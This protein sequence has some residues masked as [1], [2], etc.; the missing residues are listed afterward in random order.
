LRFTVVDL[1]DLSLINMS[2]L[3]KALFGFI[4]LLIV[5][6]PGLAFAGTT[7]PYTPTYS[8]P[9]YSYASTYQYPTYSYSNPSRYYKGEHVAYTNSGY[10]SLG[11]TYVPYLPNTGFEPQSS[12]A[13][14]FALVVL[15]TLAIFSY[16]YV[17]KAFIVV[18]G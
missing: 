15:I 1:V 4:A 8:Y 5:S 13:I 12:F 6:I 7:Y 16:P 10:V 2:T 14:A 18:R 9:N 3:Y 17:R 11:T